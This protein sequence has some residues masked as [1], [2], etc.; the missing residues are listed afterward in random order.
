M[1]FEI[2]NLSQEVCYLPAPVSNIYT[3][4]LRPELLRHCHLSKIFEER[5]RQKDD[6]VLLTGLVHCS[7]ALE[8]DKP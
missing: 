7:L 2:E 6:V 1:S 3:K 8:R 4:L 5:M